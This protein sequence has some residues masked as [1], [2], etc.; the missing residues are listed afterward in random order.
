MIISLNK[1][2]LFCFSFLLVNLSGTS[3]MPQQG[4]K[5]RIYDRVSKVNIAAIKVLMFRA[6][7]LS[8][9]NPDY[10]FGGS[11]D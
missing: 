5:D 3:N 11:N 7:I 9:V 6:L 4:I 1:I 8:S 2:K 10:I